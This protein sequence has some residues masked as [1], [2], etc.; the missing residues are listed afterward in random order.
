MK[1]IMLQQLETSGHSLDVIYGA[2]RGNIT[3]LVVNYTN[4][5]SSVN[6]SPLPIQLST[7]LCL[8]EFYWV[9]HSS[10]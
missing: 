3:F 2:R 10:L 7:Y 6:Q 9:E 5:N 4:C 8:S 1:M